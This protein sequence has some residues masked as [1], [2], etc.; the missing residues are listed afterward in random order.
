METRCGFKVRGSRSLRPISNSPL[1]TS[2]QALD[3]AAVHGKISGGNGTDQ[4]FATFD[5]AGDNPSCNSEFIAG[6]IVKEEN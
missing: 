3:S 2:W 4:H 5:N 6:L 1:T